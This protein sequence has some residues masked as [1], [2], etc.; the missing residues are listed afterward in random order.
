M[1]SAQKMRAVCSTQRVDAMLHEAFDSV[2][3]NSKRFDALQR[4][5]S[6]V[7]S[8]SRLVGPFRDTGY[9]G[10]IGA[11]AAIAGLVRLSHCCQDWLREPEA[12]QPTTLSRRK[13]LGDLA[14]HLLANHPVP[15]FMDCVWWS[16]DDVIAQYRHWFRHVGLGN[17]VRGVSRCKLSKTQ[18]RR[19]MLAPDHFTIEQALVWCLSER[20][21]PAPTVQLASYPVGPSRRRLKRTR[22]WADRPVGRHVWPRVGIDDYFACETAAE[23]EPRSW[24]IRQIRHPDDLVHE[25]RIMKH[26]VGS[27]LEECEEGKTT[28]WSLQCKTQFGRRHMLTIEVLP[29]SRVISEALGFE[30]RPAKAN[31]IAILKSWAEQQDLIMRP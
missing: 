29:K 2:R 1:Y 19:F 4:L 24:F 17:S 18:A 13:Q 26:C 5:V 27:Y 16:D 10:W 30:N 20:E 25:G 7:R 8:V 23:A 15:R 11:E 28:I 21:M 12:W 9:V 31:E 22:A 6:H 14:R 3:N